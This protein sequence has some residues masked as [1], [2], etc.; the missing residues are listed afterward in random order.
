MLGQPFLSS[1][2]GS[3][4]HN[5]WPFNK[6]AKFTIIVLIYFINSLP[7]YIFTYD[8]GRWLHITYINLMITFFYLKRT[9]KIYSEKK[10]EFSFILI[11]YT[12]LKKFIL[13]IILIFYSSILSVSYFGGYPYW[14]N[15]YTMIDDQLKFNFKVI[16]TL[17]HLFKN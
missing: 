13:V 11:N 14:L 8:W 1:G 4:M 9:N 10:D 3:L 7:L 6:N 15:N 16:K 17:P 12:P 2:W 5:D